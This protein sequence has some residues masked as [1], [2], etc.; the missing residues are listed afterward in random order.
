MLRC[1]VWRGR[2]RSIGVRGYLI[3]LSNGLANSLLDAVLGN[4]AYPPSLAGDVPTTP[5]ALYVALFTVAPAADGT[6]GT[7]VSGSGYARAAVTQNAT[8]W[9]AASEGS[10]SN[11]ATIAFG[12]AA[13]SWGTA[14]AFGIYDAVTGGNLL[15]YGPLTQPQSITTGDGVQVQAGGLVVSLS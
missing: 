7:E 14:T 2:F 4:G 8:N 12:T 6:G 15:L 3:V 1:W 10:K 13:G 9:P 11:G 5:P